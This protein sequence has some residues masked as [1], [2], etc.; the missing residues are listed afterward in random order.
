MAW[1]LQ[2]TIT[3]ANEPARNAFDILCRLLAAPHGLPALFSVVTGVHS[4]LDTASKFVDNPKP[5]LG[6]LVESFLSLKQHLGSALGIVK[7]TSSKSELIGLQTRHPEWTLLATIGSEAQHLLADGYVGL[8]LLTLIYDTKKLTKSTVAR[9]KEIRKEEP[10][11]TDLV[12]TF[13]RG[14][15]PDQFLGQSWA[16]DLV[17]AWRQAV[18]AY[19]ADP[20]P[21]PPTPQERVG[22]QMLSAAIHG[23]TQERAGA[24]SHRQLSPRQ[25]SLAAK[26]IWL[27]V[28]E[29]LLVGAVGVISAITTF[30]V[31]IVPTIPV[32][33]GDI[34][35]DWA[36]GLNIQTGCL[37]IDYQRLV[38]Q[39]A[40]PLP[41]S[42]PSSFLCLRPLPQLLA[43]RLKR[44]HLIYPLAKSLCD[45]Y[46]DEVAPTTGQR[47]TR[48][49]SGI[50]STWARLRTS[51]SRVLREQGFDAFVVSAITGDF[52]IVARSK[53]Y[54]ASASQKE[55]ERG[56]QVLY[57][58]LEWGAPTQ[59]PVALNFGCQVVPTAAAIQKLDVYLVSNLAKAA[60]GRHTSVPPLIDFHNCYMRLVG[61]RLSVLLALRETKEFSVLA[62]FDEDT[63]AWIPIHDKE[64][65]NDI[66]F[67]PVPV[68]KFLVQT[69]KAYRRHCNAMHMRLKTLELGE[70]DLTR[71]CLQVVRK[72]AVPLLCMADVNGSIQQ[73]G[74]MDFM[75]EGDWASTLPPDFG[76]KTM[77]NMLRKH[78]IRA[79]DIDSILRHSLKGQGHT[80]ATSDF[81]PVCFLSRY[82]A[83]MSSITTELYGDAIYGLSKE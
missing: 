75:E 55:T 74:T 48:I 6:D 29:D 77:E 24:Q 59:Q 70:S 11:T 82:E 12:R 80:G 56:F 22:S 42:V 3:S 17:R 58:S 79:S 44:R 15:T 25:Y 62:S 34:D 67:M 10:L 45:L 52:T 40:R 60:P 72:S 31:D 32:L 81:S 71:W 18:K 23:T 36:I 76:R 47:I 9:A 39:A 54:Y 61:A 7:K 21:P 38:P 19:A 83:A 50:E 78:G 57:R 49:A 37:Q 53:L 13:L 41:G 51:T 68:C 73:L 46:P 2:S 66:G 26:A 8:K 64:V 14:T 28:N 4:C 33:G 5:E 63:D 1:T 20:T 30:S 69:I 16:L 27:A 35:A 43:E 65:P